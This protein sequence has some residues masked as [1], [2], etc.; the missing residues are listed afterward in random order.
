MIRVS[1]SARTG[2]LRAAIERSSALGAC[3]E[4]IS[5]VSAPYLWFCV[6]IT[7]QVLFAATKQ[8]S[9]EDRHLLV[10]CL[11]RLQNLHQY[12]QAQSEPKKDKNKKNKHDDDPL[13]P[14]IQG[15]IL[16]QSLLRLSSPHN[17]PVID[18]QDLCIAITSY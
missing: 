7:L 11:L 6:P 18:R 2:V 10:P 8:N 9:A 1:D 17:Q 5:E 3:Q 14:K 12:Q 15:A 16:L 13:A 4:G